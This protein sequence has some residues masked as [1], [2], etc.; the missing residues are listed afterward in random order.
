MAEAGVWL[1]GPHSHHRCVQLRLTGCQLC[2]QA[3]IGPAGASSNSRSCAL[4]GYLAS[5]PQVPS[6]SGPFPSWGW[7]TPDPTP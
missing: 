1:R 6:T 3:H 4:N 5:K 7:L 2:A